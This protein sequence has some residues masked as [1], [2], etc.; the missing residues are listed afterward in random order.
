MDWTLT[1]DLDT[2]GAAAGDF[3]RSRPVQHTVH[4]SVAE[5]LR[6]RGSSAYGGAAPV[7]GWLR[8][9]SGEVAAAALQTPPY[10]V[11]L[12]RLP[13]R[14]A[15][16]LAQAIA[17]RGAQLPGVNATDNDATAFGVAW[18]GLVGGSMR[19]HQR[20]RLFRLA[21]LEPPAPGPAGA[22]RV[23][24]SR[25]RDLLESWFT[26]F[27]DEAGGMSGRVAGAV[28]DRLSYG[29]ITLWE[30]DGAAVSMAG[31]TRPV[32]GT[33]RVGPVYTPPELR[34]RGYAA[35]VTAAVSQAALD[36]GASHVVLFTDLANPTSNA[37]Y[38]RLGYRAVEDRVVLAFS[39]TSGNPG[40]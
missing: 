15:Q 23:A 5:T 28:D 16:S 38:Q 37:L 26:A 31:V 3:L 12:T 20:H 13:E 35:G 22:P 8:L 39:G 4:L 27:T 9:A 10:P 7:F 29:G 21:G 14:S 2:F 34:R 33:V 32:A 6:V 36:A 24:T 18:T 19:E 11:M 40:T 1:E 25:D 30:D 17:A